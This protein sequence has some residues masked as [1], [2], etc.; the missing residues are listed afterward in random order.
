MSTAL[1]LTGLRQLEILADACKKALHPN[2]PEHARV[3]SKY[4]DRTANKLTR[5]IVD[6]FGYQRHFATRLSS[7]GTF[8][9]DLGKYVPSQQRLGMP[10]I[11]AIVEGRAVHVEV[12][13]A[14]DYLSDDQKETMAALKTSGAVVFVASTFQS[15]FDFYQAEFCQTPF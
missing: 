9:T 1:P 4:S 11:Y 3:K 6:W 14:K 12:K 13:V 15:F 8:R 7:S 10:D 2:F 5:A